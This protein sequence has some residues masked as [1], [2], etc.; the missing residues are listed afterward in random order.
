[1]SHGD[2]SKAEDFLQGIKLSHGGHPQ[3]KSLSPRDRIKKCAA[4]LAKTPDVLDLLHASLTRVL[5]DPN[6]E[7]LRKVNVSAGPFKKHVADK[8]RAGLELLYAVGYEPLHGYLV[9]QKHDAFLLSLAI[10]ALDAE[11]SSTT[12]IDAKAIQVADHTR[13]QAAMQEAAS[14]ATRRAAHL[15]K[16]PA[17]PKA[18]EVDAASS[19]CVISVRLVSVEGE[20]AADAHVV[21]RRFAS[22]NTLDDLINYV[23]SL[24]RIPEATELSIENVTTRPARTLDPTTQGSLSLYA[25]DLWPRGQVQVREACA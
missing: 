25:L 8:S 5:N 18:G 10:D 4:L 3:R 19:V 11:R 13:S 1:M 12:F 2:C 6:S 7:R 15:A 21:T 9:L 17:E 14:A 16:V 22:D 24:D 23:R 20:R